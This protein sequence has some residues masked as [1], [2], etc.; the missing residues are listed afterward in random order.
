[1]SDS[2]RPPIPPADAGYERSDTHGKPVFIGLLIGTL[3][4]VLIII[5]LSQLFTVTH[6]E[7][8]YQSV[9]SQKNPRLEEIR[10]EETRVL[11]TY[12]LIDSTNGQ[13]RIPIDRAMELMVEEA[14]RR[15]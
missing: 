2:K 13:V 14:S 4:L 5:G 8:V 9:L 3:L 12:A 1:M 6:E 15:P 7:I 11:T 10:G